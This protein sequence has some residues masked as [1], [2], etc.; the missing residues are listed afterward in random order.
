MQA[1]SSFSGFATGNGSHAGIESD[2]PDSGAPLNALFV[3]WDPPNALA[4]SSEMN[5]ME[6]AS[7]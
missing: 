4:S 7:L 6:I 5:V 1:D 2:P 3:E